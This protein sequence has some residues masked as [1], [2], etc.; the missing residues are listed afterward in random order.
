M[1][2]AD[3]PSWACSGVGLHA[4]NKY[5]IAGRYWTSHT[6]AVC[7]FWYAARLV[8]FCRG[9]LPFSLLTSVVRLLGIA[10]QDL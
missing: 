4:L 3:D 5:Y 9:S 10:D 1:P 6:R 8:S 2:M 7:L